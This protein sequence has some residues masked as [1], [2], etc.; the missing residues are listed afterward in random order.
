MEIIWKVLGSLEALSTTG[1]AA[2]IVR[3]CVI[4]LV[5]RADDLLAEDSA[6]ANTA[7]KLAIAHDASLSVEDIHAFG[8]R[9]PRLHLDCCKMLPRWCHCDPTD[10]VRNL[11]LNI[12][13]Q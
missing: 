9:N 1:R 11:R 8:M 13:C 7:N 12:R 5:E 4:L 10:T 3:L 2:K 6:C